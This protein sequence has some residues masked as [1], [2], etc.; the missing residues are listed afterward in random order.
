MVCSKSEEVDLYP[1][2]SLCHCRACFFFSSSFQLAA[3]PA[4][5][6]SAEPWPAFN[7]K[8]QKA[9][10]RCMIKYMKLFDVSALWF[11]TWATT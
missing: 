11:E 1:A 9:E 4:S 3:P 8:R 2:F 6:C 5:A 7:R 10:I